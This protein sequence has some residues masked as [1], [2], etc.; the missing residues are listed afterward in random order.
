VPRHA[1]SSAITACLST[2]FSLFSGRRCTPTRR[3]TPVGWIFIHY[4]IHEKRRQ[5][6]DEAK[7]FT[8]RRADIAD[9]AKGPSLNSGL[10]DLHVAVAGRVFF[11][12]ANAAHSGGAV[13][14]TVFQ[15]KEA[16]QQFLIPKTQLDGGLIADVAERA[17]KGEHFGRVLPLES[18]VVTA[19][20]HNL[21]KHREP[22]QSEGLPNSDGQSFHACQGRHFDA[23][24]SESDSL[25]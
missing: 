23:H 4:L 13:P 1:W 2:S 20:M 17:A 6:H 24:H 14:Y 5:V 3:K 11:L 22:S 12:M 19:I 18:R 15:S 9:Q 10:R 25:S 8:S 16:L 21:F 7:S